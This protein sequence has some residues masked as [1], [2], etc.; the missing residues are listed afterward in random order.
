MQLA[1]LATLVEPPLPQAYDTGSSNAAFSI[2]ALAESREF[3]PDVAKR[4]VP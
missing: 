2:L 4:Y 1:E 3:Q